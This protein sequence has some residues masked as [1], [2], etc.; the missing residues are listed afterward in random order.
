MSE[1]DTSRYAV[2]SIS[3]LPPGKRRIVQIPDGP[4]V[5]IFNVGGELRALKNTCPHHGGPLCEG[6][7][8]GTS[9]ARFAPS[10]R[11]QIDWND[12]ETIVVR[13]PWHGWEFDMRTGVA[14]CGP[15]IRTATY[16]VELGS[17][18]DGDVPGPAE[19]FPVDVEGDVVI[20]EVPA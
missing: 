18:A 2:C 13:C 10:R 7:V 8:A 6:V 5:G 14:V 11:P 4:E 16:P 1:R 15:R 3:D 12:G 17:P 20:V 19:I 9:T